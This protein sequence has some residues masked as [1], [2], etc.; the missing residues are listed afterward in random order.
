MKNLPKFDEETIC[1]I[2]D[3]K[4]SPKDCEKIL[5]DNKDKISPPS[6]A[7]HNGTV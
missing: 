2:I 1:Y 5:N 4:I 3:N 6:S 7:G